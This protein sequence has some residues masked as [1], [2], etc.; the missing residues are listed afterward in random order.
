VASENQQLACRQIV[1]RWHARGHISALQIVAQFVN[2]LPCYAR[3]V[4]KSR[5]LGRAS[6]IGAMAAGAPG[7]ERVLRD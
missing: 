1:E 2:R 6:R 3:V 4:R 7:R 5:P